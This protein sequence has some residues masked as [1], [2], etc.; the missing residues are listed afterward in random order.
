MTWPM[1][2][3]VQFAAGDLASAYTTTTWLSQKELYKILVLATRKISEQTQ[4]TDDMRA[5][6][7]ATC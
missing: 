2:T 1:L 4:I 5:R 6:V 7:G 3:V